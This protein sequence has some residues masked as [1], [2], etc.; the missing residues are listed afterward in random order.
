MDGPFLSRIIL[1]QRNIALNARKLLVEI[2]SRKLTYPPKMAFWRW[3]SFLGYVIPWGIPIF[4]LFFPWLGGGSGHPNTVG[5]TRRWLQSLR[6][7]Q[8]QSL[9]QPC[10]SNRCIRHPRKTTKHGAVFSVSPYFFGGVVAKWWMLRFWVKKL[11]ESIL[12]PKFL[13]MIYFDVFFPP[14]P[15]SSF[16][17]RNGCQWDDVFQPFWCRTPAGSKPR[18]LPQGFNQ[19]TRWCFKTWFSPRN[20]GKSPFF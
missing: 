18:Q 8:D 1:V 16:Q 17:G 20:L 10:S 5:T 3:F 7:P 9:Q 2:P 12:R 11:V 19:S 15:D 14:V 4:L 13:E 6:K